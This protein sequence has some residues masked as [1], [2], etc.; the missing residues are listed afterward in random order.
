MNAGDFKHPYFLGIGG[1]G[2]SALAWY[3]LRKGCLVHGYDR[4]PSPLTRHL[5]QAG[6]E[7]HYDEDPEKLPADTDV[8]VYTPAIPQDHAEWPEIHR[9]EIPV[10]KRAEVLG[11]I[12]RDYTT[13]AVAG[14]HGKT[15]TSSML[16]YLLRHSV[17]CNA[18]LGGVSLDLDG[19]YHYDASS[20]LMVTE[21]DEYDRSFWQ[22]YPWFS[23]VTAWDAD[24][25][26]VYG[27]VENMRAAYCRFMR[28][29]TH[30][31]ACES[32]KAD[33][34]E[35]K[36]DYFYGQDSWEE[37]LESGFAVERVEEG[38]QVSAR[39][40]HVRVQNGAYHFDYVGPR[41]AIC[42]L[43]LHCPGRHNVLNAVA[44]ISLALE[45]GVESGDVKRLL[46]GFKGVARRLEL[47]DRAVG[48]LY[49]YD[50]YAHHPAEIKASVDALREFYPEARLCIVFQPHLYTRTRDLADGFARSLSEADELFLVDIYP[51]RELP[52]DGV[53][54]HL[55]GD[56]IAGKEVHYGSREDALAW[57]ERR[58]SRM[59]ECAGCLVLV[60]MGAGDIDRIVDQV[61]ALVKKEAG[62]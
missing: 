41:A 45:S 8:V 30:F 50:D 56:K 58:I 62:V 14:T 11:M 13:L 9:R 46:P 35:P 32:M 34:R 31:I 55:I 7:I 57:I 5:E 44:A 59:R 60:T 49:Y 40:V 4:I 18:I 48:R 33:L 38:R 28:Q 52:L 21:A 27:S 61:G 22:L 25:L 16:A 19:N 54:T 42:G 26:D 51:A 37:N 23:A 12:C 10:L 6:A 43:E 47:K 17:G 1:I 39:A 20:S 15:T 2:M 3:Y 29:S 36:A 53:D 24:H